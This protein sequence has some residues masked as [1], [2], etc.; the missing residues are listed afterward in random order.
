M[1]VCPEIQLPTPPIGYVGVKLCGRQV[2][3][4]EHLLDGTEIGSAFEQV[5]REGVAEQVGM[6]AVRVEAGLLCAALE[7][8]E[9]ARARERAAL[10]VQEELRAMAPVEV[11]T[12][13]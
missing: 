6:D 7:D 13:A 1:R 4:A 10:R 9:G 8:E 3:V 2:G 5:G 12:A 11:R